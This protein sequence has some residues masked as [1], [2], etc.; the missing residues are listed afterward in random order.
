MGPHSAARHIDTQWCSLA[1]FYAWWDL[2]WLHNQHRCNRDLNIKHRELKWDTVDTGSIRS[3][4]CF[5]TKPEVFCISFTQ[6]CETQSLPA[7]PV[8]DLRTQGFSSPA[9][10]LHHALW[11]AG[12]RFGIY[13]HLLL[14]HCSDGVPEAGRSPEP[15][16]GWPWSPK[17]LEMTCQIHSRGICPKREDTPV[18]HGNSVGTWWSQV[19]FRAQKKLSRSTSSMSALAQWISEVTCAEANNGWLS[20]GKRQQEIDRHLW[21]WKKIHAQNIEYP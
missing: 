16:M 14:S 7:A 15:P 20:G 19:G 11:N 3:K 5:R 21:K 1:A 13:V 2:I 18:Q 17:K 9:E 10:P 4:T 12:C 8:A 6:L